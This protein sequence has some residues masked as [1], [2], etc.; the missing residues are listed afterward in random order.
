MQ[1]YNGYLRIPIYF[2]K[3][4]FNPLIVANGTQLTIH[5]LCLTNTVTNGGLISTSSVVI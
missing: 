4:F 2:F 3:I 5:N 1:F